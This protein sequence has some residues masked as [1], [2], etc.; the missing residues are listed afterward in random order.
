MTNMAVAVRADGLQA[1]PS[2]QTRK[3]SNVAGRVQMIPTGT[4]MPKV[5]C[6]AGKNLIADVREVV[7]RSTKN[8]RIYVFLCKFNSNLRTSDVCAIISCMIKI[9][10]KGH[11]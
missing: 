4:R 9:D 1:L 6:E 7:D 8:V 3:F 5:R 11:A 10:W 2:L